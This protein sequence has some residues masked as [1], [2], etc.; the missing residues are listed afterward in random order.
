MDL[1]LCRHMGEGTRLQNDMEALR[2][3]LATY[4]QSIQ[5]KDQVISNLTNG[6]Q[7]HRNRMEVQRS[8]TE[9]K[10][11]HN[12]ARR[13][14]FLSFCTI[15]YQRCCLFVPRLKLDTLADRLALNSIPIKIYSGITWFSLR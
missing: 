6:M 13:E 14:V 8:F 12:D 4:E 5:R 15:L 11:K 3:L 7:H 2:E 10:L 1:L 9:W